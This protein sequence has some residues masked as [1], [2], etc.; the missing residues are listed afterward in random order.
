[1]IEKVENYSKNNKSEGFVKDMF[2]GKQIEITECIEEQDEATIEE[3]EFLMILLNIQVLLSL[4]PL[5][6]QQ[7]L[8]SL[9]LEL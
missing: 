3:G 1:M 2:Y 7:P 5:A 6:K 8:W 9:G 4:N